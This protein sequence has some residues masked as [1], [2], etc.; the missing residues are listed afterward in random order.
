M[1][2]SNPARVP[3]ALQEAATWM[4]R[5][6][7]PGAGESDRLAFA[8]WLKRSP[9]H[10]GHYLELLDLDVELRDPA[11]FTGMAL[12]PGQEVRNV[13]P[14]DLAPQTNDLPAVSR[15]RAAGRW[16]MAAAA[17]IAV[18][19]LG[20]FWSF[21][22]MN[23]EHYRSGV[24]E[25]RSIA[26]PDG[27][28]VT[29]NTQSEIEVS[30]TEQARTLRL[31]RGEAFFRVARGHARPFSVEVDDAVVQALGTAFNVYRRADGHV[32][33]V[34]EGRVAV[35]MA[36]SSVPAKVL[37]AGEQTAVRPRSDV[38]ELD[39]A[40]LARVMGWTQRQLIFDNTPVREVVEE[41]N[42][43]H[44][45]R[46]VINDAELGARAVTGTFESGDPD[47]FVEFLVKQGA[48]ATR[49]PDGTVHIRGKGG[50]SPP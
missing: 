28:L 47:S 29:L 8:Q 15:R 23:G 1:N 44:R 7:D 16:S 20:M 39:Q 42:R 6:R 35:R 30:Y 18:L 49:E 5:L 14:L 37:N 32:V 9:L 33:T 13:V 36:E 19:A 22:R 17:A 3:E 40:T 38:A 27:S 2:P 12:T 4:T 50:E 10:V 41:L 24:G 26:L 43:Y 25:L 34:T 48:S 45:H 31:V 21:D 46:L 11:L